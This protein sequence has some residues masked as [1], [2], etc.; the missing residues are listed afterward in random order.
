MAV[1]VNVLLRLKGL[2]GPA[3]ERERLSYG[4]GDHVKGDVLTMS[5]KRG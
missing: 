4:F 1:S 3:K 2:V 5:R